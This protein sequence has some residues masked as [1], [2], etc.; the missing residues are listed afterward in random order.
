MNK[1]Y[2]VVIGNY[3]GQIKI[4]HHPKIVT[5]NKYTSATKR[6]YYTNYFWYKQ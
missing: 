5:R 3:C 4:G 2:W 1:Y 6:T